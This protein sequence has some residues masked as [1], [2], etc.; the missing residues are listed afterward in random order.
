LAATTIFAFNW[1]G[2]TL[3]YNEPPSDL[4]I[5]GETV[6]IVEEFNL[7]DEYTAGEPIAGGAWI[8]ISRDANA[9][10]SSYSL[11]GVASIL[12]LVNPSSILY[13]LSFGQTNLLK[14]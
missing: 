11:V 10:P 9:R 7:P 6:F 13:G 4:V 1:C 5:G 2:Y 12:S 8:G 3:Y 14:L